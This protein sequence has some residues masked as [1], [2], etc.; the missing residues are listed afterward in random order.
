[1]KPNESRGGLQ[2]DRPLVIL[3]FL[4]LGKS[5]VVVIQ[6]ELEEEDVF[7]RLGDGI[8]PSVVGS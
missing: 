2:L 6:L 8:D 3:L 1:M 5:R 7:V 4:D